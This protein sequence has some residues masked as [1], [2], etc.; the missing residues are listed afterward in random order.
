MKYIFLL[1]LPLFIQQA[2]ADDFVLCY[3]YKTEVSKSDDWTRQG[4]VP[5]SYSF[6]TEIIITNFLKKPLME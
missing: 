2:S 1:F 4:P 3:L 6:L 5:G